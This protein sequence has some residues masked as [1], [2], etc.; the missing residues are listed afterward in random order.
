MRQ[1]IRESEQ[2]TGNKDED[3]RPNWL[4]CPRHWR[5]QNLEREKVKNGNQKKKC[6]A[7]GEITIGSRS[8][9]DQSRYI[10]N[11]GHCRRKN[12]KRRCRVTFEIGLH[13][14]VEIKNA[15][16]KVAPNAF[17]GEKNHND[18]GHYHG[19]GEKHRGTFE[20]IDPAFVQ[21]FATDHSNRQRRVHQH[22]K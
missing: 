8:T 19:R 22:G 15:I 14:K 12:K 7:K 6:A 4:K 20:E 2:R 1:S 16:S 17:E 10:N 13:R 9:N 5:P 3:E 21:F 11:H 18:D